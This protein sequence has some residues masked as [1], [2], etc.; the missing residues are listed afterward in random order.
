[1]ECSS[2]SR[3][4]H[5]LVAKVQTSQFL[6]SSFM[7]ISKHLSP[8]PSMSSTLRHTKTSKRAVSMV[9]SEMFKT[10]SLSAKSQVNQHSRDLL[11]P[12]YGCIVQHEDTFQDQKEASRCIVWEMRTIT[13]VP[14]VQKHGLRNTASTLAFMRTHFQDWHCRQ[15]HIDGFTTR[16]R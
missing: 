13:R 7:F 15:Q 9:Q 10:D 8:I 5:E 4:V 11:P 6:S 14:T 3:L 1:M 2:H 12:H 16:S